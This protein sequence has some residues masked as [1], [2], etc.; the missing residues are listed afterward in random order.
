MVRYVMLCYVRHDVVALVKQSAMI[1]VYIIYYS[2]PFDVSLF[3]FY[4]A[5]DNLT[6]IAIANPTIYLHLLR[7]P[8]LFLSTAVLYPTLG[9][10]LYII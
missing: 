9:C 7:F 4:L 1:H 10:T 8:Y 6:R 2:F 5:F 3:I